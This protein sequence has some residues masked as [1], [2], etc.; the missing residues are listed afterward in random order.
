MEARMR[1]LA[2]QVLAELRKKSNAHLG[3]DVER[4]APFSVTW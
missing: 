3:G 1:A 2:D 4:L